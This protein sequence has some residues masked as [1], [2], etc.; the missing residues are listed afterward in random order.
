MQEVFSRFVSQLTSFQD[1]CKSHLFAT[2]DITIDHHG[3]FLFVSTV[4]ILVVQGRSALISQRT[5]A[6]KVPPLSNRKCQNWSNNTGY[7]RTK[8]NWELWPYK[9]YFEK[10][11]MGLQ[12]WKINSRFYFLH[13]CL[14]LFSF[15][16]RLDNGGTFIAA[17]LCEIRADGLRTAKMRTVDTNK[18]QPWW[19]IVVS[20]VSKNSDLHCA[21]SWLKNRE[22][23][24]STYFK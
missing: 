9:F 12:R 11:R 8:W 20:E 19:L 14:V 16:F 7:V 13:T 1:F 5:A 15:K 4:L 6:M 24:K 10:H 17:V 21:C 2:F 3:L 18:K 23:N 22:L